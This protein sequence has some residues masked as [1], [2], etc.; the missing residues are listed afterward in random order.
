MNNELPHITTLKSMRPE[1]E[2]MLIRNGLSKESHCPSQHHRCGVFLDMQTPNIP[3]GK[4]RMLFRRANPQ[5]CKDLALART[6]RKVWEVVQLI[7]H[8]TNTGKPIMESPW[9]ARPFPSNR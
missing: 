2:A 1:V 8:S 3:T 4:E 6:F 5:L 7:E 9:A